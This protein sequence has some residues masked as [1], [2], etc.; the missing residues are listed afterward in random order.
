MREIPINDAVM[1]N[2]S[3]RPDGRV[4]HDVYLY[5]VKTLAESKGPWDYLKLLSTIPADPAFKP[6]DASCSLVK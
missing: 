5:Q 6:M 2:A 1:R 4:I 3:I